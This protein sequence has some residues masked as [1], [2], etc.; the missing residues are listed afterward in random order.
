MPGTRGKAWESCRPARR[1]RARLR[2]RAGGI[3]TWHSSTR[4]RRCGS[5][6]GG[7][8]PGA[9]CGSSTAR[10]RSRPGVHALAQHLHR[11]G[12]AQHAPRSEVVP[13]GARSRRSPSRGR[14]PG[15]AA[16]A[17]GEVST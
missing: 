1:D 7:R 5:P 6:R 4:M 17:L 11:E 8:A 10:S 2:H 9:G 16:D 13:T 3:S 12:A 15:S 14:P